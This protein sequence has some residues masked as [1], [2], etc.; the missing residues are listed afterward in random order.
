[1]ALRSGPRY[2]DL[3][4]QVGEGTK[5]L[6]SLGGGFPR[7]ARAGR[8]DLL[9]QACRALQALQRL[10]P[11]GTRMPLPVL[12]LCAVAVELHRRGYPAMAR[13]TMVCLDAYLFEET[14]KSKTMVSDVE[15]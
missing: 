10:H 3:E 4:R 13:L 12:A 5:L 1:M 11:G 7:Y 2:L 15:A 6:A 9:P 14:N 8:R